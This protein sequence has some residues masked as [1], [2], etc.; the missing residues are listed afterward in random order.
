M[1]F[2]LKFVCSGL[3]A[4]YIFPS[5]SSHF[6]FQYLFTKTVISSFMYC[7]QW[8]FYA[9]FLLHIPCNTFLCY[10]IFDMY[11]Q[12]LSWSMCLE[13][14]FKELSLIFAFIDKPTGIWWFIYCGIF[15][16]LL[17]YGFVYL[18]LGPFLWPPWFPCP[19]YLCVFIVRENRDRRH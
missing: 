6:L 9:Y 11:F 4:M 10:E 17:I 1:Y 19:F 7:I 13:I 3:L 14:L 16:F 2:F 18:S 15:L 8:Y 5:I 12:Y